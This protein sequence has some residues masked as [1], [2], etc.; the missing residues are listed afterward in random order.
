MYLEH[1][2]EIQVH[3]FTCVQDRK[4]VNCVVKRVPSRIIHEAVKFSMIGLAQWKIHHM[5]VKRTKLHPV[6]ALFNVKNLQNSNL[7]QC[8]RTTVFVM[9][10][11]S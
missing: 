4:L 3:Q 10:A 9:R 6:P 8:A 2:K 5:M 1:S 11:A 7:R